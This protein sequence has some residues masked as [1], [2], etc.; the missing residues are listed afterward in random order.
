MWWQFH[1][2]FRPVERCNRVILQNKCLVLCVSLFLRHIATLNFIK[3]TNI[4]NVVIKWLKNSKYWLNVGYLKTDVFWIRVQIKV[5]NCFWCK[6][7][8]IEF[9]IRCSKQ[10]YHCHY[11]I[12]AHNFDVKIKKFY[13]VSFS[14]LKR[15]EAF[16]KLKEGMRGPFT[17]HVFVN[18][19]LRFVDIK[20]N[21]LQK[22]VYWNCILLT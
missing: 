2:M 16:R 19:V 1:A 18:R 13:Y 9:K 20:K 22:S 14:Y 3:L 17:G 8:D 10:S 15:L 7:N 21:L 5:A 12:H 11:Q 6:M 4:Y